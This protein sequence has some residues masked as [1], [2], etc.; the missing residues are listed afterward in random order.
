MQKNPIPT[1]SAIKR[2]F[3]QWGEV[4]EVRDCRNTPTQ[5]FVEYYDLRDSEKACDETN[6][7]PLDNDGI[8]EVKYAFN[9]KMEEMAERND[10]RRT[11]REDDYNSYD[12]Y[13]SSYDQYDQ[14]D[15][16]SSKGGGGGP[17]RD[18]YS[19]RNRDYHESDYGQYASPSSYTPVPAV[20]SY[21]PQNQLIQTIAQLAAGL[22][23]QKAANP[24]G[25]PQNTN[26]IANLL[27]AQQL[28]QQQTGVPSGFL[29][30]DGTPNMNIIQQLM[31]QNKQQQQQNNSGQK[32]STPPHY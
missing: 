13:E 29:N 27:L 12:S 30:A 1:N 20:G 22:L 31:D 11:T 25:A 32:H 7:A 23:A 16:Y 19:D 5:K 17:A 6:G 3:E 4:R 9:S 14:Y 28:N 24:Y 18:R 10:Y 2:L 21:D 15:S 8:M 26:Q